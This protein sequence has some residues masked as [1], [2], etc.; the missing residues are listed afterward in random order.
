MN[1]NLN[2]SPLRTSLITWTLL[3]IMPVIGMIVDLV[4]PSLPA[5]TVDLHVTEAVVKNVIT[6]FLLGYAIGNFITG[7]ITDALGRQKLIRYS[8]LVFVIVSI[9]PAICPNIHMILFSRFM[10][11]ISSGAAAVLLRAIF[12]DILPKERLIKLGAI[13]G[14]MWGIGPI[15]GPVIGGYLQEH[16][17]WKTGFYFFTIIGFLCLI[18]VT[19]IVPETIATRNKL[20]YAVI[21][22]NSFEILGNRVFI[23]LPIIM[24][25]AYSFIITFHTTGPF[26]IQKVL[27]HSPLFFGRLAL[28][29]GVSFLIATFVARYLISFMSVERIFQLGLRGF[30]V[31]ILLLLVLSH[32]ANMPLVFMIIASLIMFFAAGILFP[33]SMGKGISMF[34]HIAGTATAI[35]YLINGSI[36]AAASFIISLLKVNNTEIILLIYFILLVICMIIYRAMIRTGNCK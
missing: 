28:C 23:A 22:N 10:Q 9:L 26:L 8:L 4:A 1:E 14:A 36:T 34:S 32:I 2:L 33:L 15:I 31:I 11:G 29:M 21:K 30:L 19:I 27:G 24:G 25:L 5:M 13:M 7:F 12:A 3:L 17:G 20:K 6:M 35:M 16:Y 18:V